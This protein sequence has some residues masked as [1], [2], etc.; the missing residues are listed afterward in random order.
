MDDLDGDPRRRPSAA[1]RRPIW[2]RVIGCVILLVGVALIVASEL[3]LIGG[4]HRHLPGASDMAYL[5]LGSIVSTSSSWWFGW[6]DR[7]S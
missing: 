7:A 1:R 2:H 3:A 5:I 6:F 4:P